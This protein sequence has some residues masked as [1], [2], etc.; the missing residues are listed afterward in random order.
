MSPSPST[1][2]QA[3]IRSW[4]LFL[5]QTQAQVPPENCNSQSSPKDI[6]GNAVS[7]APCHGQR[8]AAAPPQLQRPNQDP[9]SPAELC[10]GQCRTE[11]PAPRSSSWS[12]RYPPLTWDAPSLFTL[13]SPQGQSWVLFSLSA[14]LFLLLFCFAAVAAV[15]MLSP[16]VAMD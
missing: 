16:F 11:Q 6:L 12:T 15:A 5:A 8:L 7:M 3:T 9:T 4:D 10:T 1:A 2:L 13:K 14:P